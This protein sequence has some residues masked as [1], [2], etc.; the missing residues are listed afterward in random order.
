VDI[1][2]PP[3]SCC[4]PVVSCLPL[5]LTVSLCILLRWTQSALLHCNLVLTPTVCLPSQSDPAV[6]EKNTDDFFTSS[7][8]RPERYSHMEHRLN[9]LDLAQR[10]VHGR[11]TLFSK[12][13][14]FLLWAGLRA[15]TYKEDSTWC[16]KPPKFLCNSLKLRPSFIAYCFEIW[17]H[18]FFRDSVIEMNSFS[19]WPFNLTNTNFS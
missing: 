6:W 3:P 15:F 11:Q 8:Y 7:V 4:S 5:L 9:V 17:L 2:V 19:S 18:F 12:G 16:T 13:P 10:L 1:E 14:K